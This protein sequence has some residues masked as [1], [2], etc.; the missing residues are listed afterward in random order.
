MD[1]D[2]SHLGGQLYDLIG[3]MQRPTSSENSV[4]LAQIP[5]VKSVLNLVT[6]AAM[7]LEDYFK[8][9]LNGEPGIYCLT[10]TDSPQT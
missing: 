10:N 1:E 8:P 9:K 6:S 2:I 5:V 3:H 4:S 7:F